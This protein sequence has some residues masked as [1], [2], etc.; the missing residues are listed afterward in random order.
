M[1]RTVA[2]GAERSAD[3]PRENDACAH[4]AGGAEKG[5]AYRRRARRLQ[6]GE[7]VRGTGIRPTDIEASIRRRSEPR[8]DLAMVEQALAELMPLATI[9]VRRDFHEIAL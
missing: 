9:L 4:F 8:K 7:S 6:A 5:G 1:R 2:A 3:A